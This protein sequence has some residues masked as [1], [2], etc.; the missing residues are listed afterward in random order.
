MPDSS[1]SNKKIKVE[2]IILVII[3]VICAIACF[4]LGY[5]VKPTQASMLE[6]QALEE[7]LDNANKA[8]HDLHY[9]NKLKDAN[10]ADLLMEIN[11]L[12]SIK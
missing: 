12:K 1:D 7:Q 10:I 2:F 11:E 5:A 6:L 8:V 3:Q 9:D 4:S